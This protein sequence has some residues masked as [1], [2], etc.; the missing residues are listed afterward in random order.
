V[1]RDP[2]LLSGRAYLT[3]PRN[4]HGF[5][6]ALGLER[7]ENDPRYAD[8]KVRLTNRPQLISEIEAVPV[9]MPIDHWI[10]QLENQGVP[11][12]PTHLLRA[13]VIAEPRRP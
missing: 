7:L 2:K 9:T 11:C 8:A 3:A 10:T 5:C 13:D 12:A 4:W 1:D 6:R